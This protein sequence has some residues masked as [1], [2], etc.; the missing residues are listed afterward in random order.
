MTLNC[1]T[2]NL[3]RGSTGNAVRELQTLL[4]KLN[5]YGGKTDGEYGQLT[6]QAVQ[7]FQKQK[8]LAVDGWVGPVTCKHLNDAVGQ[9]QSYYSQGIYHSGPH[10][11][12]QG[13][14]KKG[15]CT[16]YYCAVCCIRQQLAKQ[17][18]DNYTQQT[19]AGYAGTTSAGTS[20]WGIET[21]LQVVAKKEG[22]KISVG[23]KNFSELGSTMKE[24]FEALGKLIANPSKGVILHTLYKNRYGHYETV[25][26][27]NTNNNH[28]LILN[29]LGNR[30]GGSSYCG[31]NESRSYT[32]LARNLAGISQKS[33][34]I[35][36]F[37]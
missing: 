7:T 14:N 6:E 10:W 9:T 16:G 32:E 28:C 21:A 34:C 3:K 31:W 19:L 15:Q 35:I 26:E 27:V 22:I 11:V 17:D 25:Q 24:R 18:I 8:K 12:G 37:S 33:V 1:K 2:I 13:C 5:L 36:T 23:W 20:H 30:C 4:K 29:S